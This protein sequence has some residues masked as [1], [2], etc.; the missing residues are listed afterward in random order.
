MQRPLPGVAPVAAFIAALI[1]HGAALWVW[2]PQR[3][4][5]VTPSLPLPLDLAVVASSSPTRNRGVQPSPTAVAPMPEPESEPESEPVS[6]VDKPREQPQ[7]HGQVRQQRDQAA[8]A[9]PRGGATSAVA[10]MSAKP[11]PRKPSGQ[12]AIK[13]PPTPA[14]VRSAQRQEAARVAVN[15]GASPHPPISKP[16]AAESPGASARAEALERLRQAV[17]RNKRYPLISRRRGEQGRVTVRLVLNPNGTISAV[18]VAATSGYRRLDNAALRA[19]RQASPLTGL[20][21]R[22]TGP[23]RLSL[24]MVFRLD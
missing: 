10:S 19:V 16:A 11:P 2:A 21:G 20:G 12:R 18:A 7:H 14:P 5:V 15:P 9:E 13:P 3:P 22:L 24:P 23:V 6:P 4:V 8:A 1:A 17:A